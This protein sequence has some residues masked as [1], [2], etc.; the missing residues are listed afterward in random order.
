MSSSRYQVQTLMQFAGALFVAA[1]LDAEKAQCVAEVLVTGDMVG[2][3]THG[4][5]LATPYLDEI[6][7]GLMTAHGDPEVVRDMGG[8]VQHMRD[9]DWTRFRVHLPA[10]RGSAAKGQ[11][12]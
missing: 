1:G 2:Q 6:G 8:T 11:Q 12:Q 5:K 4:L 3:R 10:A 7:K 9:G